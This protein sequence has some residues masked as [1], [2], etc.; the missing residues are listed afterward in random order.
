VHPDLS[1]FTADND[2]WRAERK[3]VPWE[4]RLEMIEERFPDAMNAD[5]NVVL[6]DDDVFA[7]ILKDILKVDQI[8]PGR[9]G[10]RPN[11]DYDRGIQTWREMTGRDYSELPFRQAFQALARMHSLTTVARKT[12]LSRSKV[13]RLLQ[14]TDRPTVV[15]LRAIAVGYG[16]KPAYFAEYRAEYVMAAMAARLAD[17]P[18]ITITLYTKLARQ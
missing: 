14:G 12:T 6:R 10:P 3:R 9:A 5:W 13:H 11:L 4:E 2:R 18:E 7:R 16:K 17:D 15:E 8:E 1:A